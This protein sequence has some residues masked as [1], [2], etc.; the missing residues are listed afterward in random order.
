MKITSNALM[1][2]KI[3]L[4]ITI[5]NTQEKELV[6][7]KYKENKFSHTYRTICKLSNTDFSIF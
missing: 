1:T 3:V 2:C 5:E 7:S 6:F 4:F